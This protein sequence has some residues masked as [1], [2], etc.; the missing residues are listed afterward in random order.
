[1]TS[2]A[3]AAT[4]FSRE[5][6]LG[7]MWLGGVLF[8]LALW[9][10]LIAG[11]INLLC[12]VIFAVPLILLAIYDKESAVLWTLVYLVLLG[13]I[14]RLVAEIGEPSA[15]DPMLLVA[16]AVAVVLVIPFLSGLRL[17]DPLSKAVLALVVIM[18]CEVV[19]PQQGGLSVGLSGVLFYMIP[20]MWFWIGRGLGSVALVEKL[21][22]RVVLPLGLCAGVWGLCQN[23]I[24]FPPYQQAWINS[25][26]KVYTSLYVGS[27]V[28]AFG[29]SVSAAEYATL[30]EISIIAAVAAYF[31]SHR[32]WIMALPMLATAL[33]LSGGRGLTIKLVVALCILW[34]V[35]KGKRLNVVK[36]LGIA[37]LGIT[38]L[39][40]LSLIAGHFAASG[41][42]GGS[43]MQDALAHQ[44]GGLAHPF[45]ARY[46]SAAQHS[47]MVTSGFSEGLKN[48]LGHG[49]G[50]TTFAAQKFGSDS[51][52]GSSELDFS[53]M[54]I[55]LGLAG[56]LLYLGV[57]IL[58]IRAAFRYS[59]ETKMKV[60]LPVLAILVATLGGWLIQGQYSTCSLV[61]FILGSVVYRENGSGARAIQSA[62]LYSREAS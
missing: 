25:V 55:S 22:Y 51:T 40:G 61:F 33:L 21:V 28:R 49:L 38:S 43:A 17:R 54:F 37:L 46:S 52:V 36:V 44:L 6:E 2:S 9:G 58:G 10:M 53:D 59:R 57:S 35:R 41:G 15:F 4:R 7:L 18:G 45:D 48:P 47:S 16:P 56:G 5:A 50:S 31:A 42:P 39:G 12:A 60:G 24:G 62:S 8:L 32:S 23:Y 11:L 30:L 3:L 14:R 27:S 29:F 26:G 13:D 34:G 1:V 19:N 20:V